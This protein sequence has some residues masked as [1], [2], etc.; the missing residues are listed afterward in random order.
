MLARRAHALVLFAVVLLGRAAGA[1]PPTAREVLDRVDDLFRS[2][3]AHGRARMTVV[4]EHWTRSLELEFWS[5]G[6]ERSLIR[7]LAPQKEKDTATLKVEKDIWNYLPKVKRVIKLPS[8][9]MSASWMGSHFTNDDLVKENRFADEYTYTVSF[10]GMRDGV[11]VIEIA[12]LPKEDAPVVWGRVVVRVRTEDW[13]PLAIDYFDE[14][15]RPA[16]RMTYGDVRLLGGRRIPSRLAVVPADKPA[17]STTVVYEAIDFDVRLDGD[18]FS[19]QN[20]Q[21]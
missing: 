10:E 2:D 12:C 20:L 7:I 11:P 6:E 9:M 21:R 15:G 8:S 16:R 18:T 4:T 14:G 3:S 17:E 5:Q 13:L 1:A 19:L